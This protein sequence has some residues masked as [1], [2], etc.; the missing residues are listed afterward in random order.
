MKKYLLIAHNYEYL[1]RGAHLTSIRLAKQYPEYL[2]YKI[3]LDAQNLEE[4]NEQYKRLIFITQVPSCY[5]LNLKFNRLKNLNYIFMLR[6]TRNPLIYNSSN[7]GFHYYRSYKNIKY[8]IPFITD[9]QIPNE[10]KKTCIGFYVRRNITPDSLAYT[11]DFLNNLKYPTDIYVMGD[12][13]P[14]FEKIKNV[15]SYTHTYDQFKFFSNISH[16]IYPTSIVHNDPFPNSV[17]EAVQCNKQIIFPALPNRVHKDGIDD[18]KDCIKWHETY[19]PDKEFDNSKCILIS[20]NFKKFYLKLFD[21]NFEYSFD[22]TKYNKF[23][24]WIEK[25]GDI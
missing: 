2:D 21:N 18:I 9:F 15:K 7:N 20:S 16:Y 3:D 12:P 1:K 10:T 17:L 25:E 23:D 4:L 14:E 6:G 11:K 24:K 8:F 19:T 5:N 13:T 22:R